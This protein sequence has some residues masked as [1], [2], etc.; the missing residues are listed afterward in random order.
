MRITS[1]KKQISRRG[2]RRRF[3]AFLVIL[4]LLLS[5][6]NLGFM[7]AYATGSKSKIFHIGTN[8]T[9]RLRDGVLTLSGTGDTDDY[10]AGTAPFLDYSREIHTLVIEKGIT[11][12]GSY[13]FYGLGEL[14]GELL[15][16]ESIIGFGDYA[17]S[18][19]TQDSAPHFTKIRNLFEFGEI[20]RL[21]ETED[22]DGSEDTNANGG[23]KPDKH[24]PV[25]DP[26]DSKPIATDSNA[27][28]VSVTDRPTQL[29]FKSLSGTDPESD[30]HISSGSSSDS[31]E[32]SFS[33][34]DKPEHTGS[35]GSSGSNSGDNNSSGSN[36][37]SSGE[38]SS[39][40]SS[41]S[42]SG[43]NNSSGSNDVSSGDNNSSGSS[44]SNSG[45]NGSSDSNNSNSDDNNSSGSNDVSSGD[46]NSSGSSDSNSGGN[47]SSDSNNSNSDDNNSSGSNDVS[48]GDNNSSGSSDSNSGDN[49]SSGCNDSNS[50]GN[51]SS[52][53]SGGGET[54][55]P[56][57]GELPA[58]EESKEDSQEDLKEEPSE[59][60]EE[61][62]KG[63]PEQLPEE[64]T[65]EELP[66]DLEEEPED[67]Y[68]I[69]DI[70][71][72]D[73]SRPETLFYPGQSGTVICS[74]DNLTF[75]EAAMAAGYQPGDDT[76]L[77][78]LDDRLELELP[79]T[80]GLLRLPDCP[81]ELS[82]PYEE[83]GLITYVFS[84]WAGTRSG[85]QA[86]PSEA[87]SPSET[88]SAE[89]ISSIEAFSSAE[90]ASPSE[91][92]SSARNNYSP[93]TASPSE[94]DSPS[95]ASALP[96]ADGDYLAAGA[97]LEV[98][99]TEHLY[100]YSVWEAT[101]R[102]QFKVMTDL[103][104]ETAVYTL[105]DKNDGRT[106]SAPDGFSFI[107]QWQ[108]APKSDDTTAEW[109]NLDGANEAVLRRVLDPMDKGMQLRC[110][111]MAIR[112]MRSLP[113]AELPTLYSD[114]ADVLA[115]IHTVYLDSENGDDSG[116]GSSQD[117]AVKTFDT[118]AQKLKTL[119]P[120]GTVTTNR[121]I[122]C[123]TYT[124]DSC[125]ILQA[126]PV[127]VTIAGNDGNANLQCITESKD[128]SDYALFLYSDLCFESITLLGSPLHIYAQG[129]N[130]TI[131]K[132]VAAPSAF[133]LYGAGKS[134]LCSDAGRNITVLSSRV[135]R[136]IG[137][138]RSSTS[139]DALNSESRI[140]IDGNAQVDSI[141]AGSASGAILN[142][143]VKINVY[144]GVVPQIIGG[145]QGYQS[146][147]S[148]YTGTTD[149]NIC[150]GTVSTVYGAGSGR[151]LSVPTYEGALK[152]T[153]N[154]GTV[155]DLYGA[156]SA[157]YITSGNTASSVEVTV[158]GGTVANLFA[159]GR[160]WDPSNNFGL[161]TDVVPV[162]KELNRPA[163]DLGSLTGTAAIK[164][165]GGTVGNIYSSGEG[166]PR[167]DH[168]VNNTKANA[169][170][171][172]SSSVTIS[173]G[174][175]TGNVYGGG[176]GIGESGYETCARIDG[177]SSI[178][179]SGSAV[180]QGDVYGGGEYGP[181]NGS[182]TVNITGGT[183][184]QSVF[185]GAVGTSGS[186]LV[187]GGSTLNMTGGLV[188]GSLYGGS[189]LSDD[190]KP[191]S[192]E[193]EI[194]DLVFVNLTGGSVQENVFGG[195]YMGTV[196]GSTH[197]HVGLNALKACSYYRQHPDEIP[198]LSASA[199]ALENS[200]YAGGDFGGE[201]VDYDAITVAGTSHVYIDGT[202]YDTGGGNSTGNPAMNIAGGVFG[203]GSSCDAG[204]TRIVTLFNYGS[205]IRDDGN[206]AT[207][208]TRTL[209]AIQRADRVLLVNSHVCLTG[210]SDVAN[211]N[212]TALYSLNRIGDHGNS[213]SL[214][215]LENGLVLQNGSTLVLESAAI[216][217]ARFASVNS[218]GN[219]V[220]LDTISQTPNTLL[221]DTGTI[222]RISYTDA[223]SGNTVYGPVSGYTYLLAGES[224]EGYVY[225]RISP[226]DS[227]P[228]GG[229]SDGEGQEIGFTSVTAATPP[230]RYWKVQ[231]TGDRE[232]VRYARLTAK[233]LT[234]NEPGYGS[235]GFSVATGVIE[236]SPA[237][238]GSVYTIKSITLPASAAGFTLAD[239]AKNGGDGSGAWVTSEINQTQGGTAI[240]LD[241]EKTAISQN[242]LSVFGLYMTPGAGFLTTGASDGK[243]ISNA[244]SS[245]GGT[246]SVIGQST[247]GTL[248]GDHVVPQIEF[249]LTYKNDI[250]ASQNL[251]TVQ[252]VIERSVDG[253][254][255]ETTVM[256]IEIV[257]TASSLSSLT[258]DLYATQGG[259]Y[260]GSLFIPA[261]SRNLILN[262]VT[263]SEG[264]NLAAEGADIK[265]QLFSLSMLPSK[266]QGWLSSGLMKEAC[267]LGS[268]TSPVR[269]GSTDSRHEAKIDFTLKNAPGFDPKESADVVTLLLEDLN[270]SDS[271]FTILVRIHW[272]K[273]IVSSVT[274]GAGRQY[275]QTPSGSSAA[276]S[277][278]S[279]VT[280]SFTVSSSTDAGG[281]WLEL[282]DKDG[283]KENLPAG[284]K[285]TLLGSTD[286]YLYQAT[287]TEAEQ[288]IRL[289]DFTSMSGR[290]NPAGMLSGT[291]T[292]ILDFGF[293][294]TPPMP[295][296]YSLRLRD[297]MGADNMGAGFTVDGGSASASLSRSGGDG[298]S[299]G[300]HKFTLTVTPGSDTRFSGGA[301]AVLSP[302]DGSSFPENVVFTVNGSNYYPNGGNVYIPLNGAGAYTLEMDTRKTAGLSGDRYT[303][304]ARIFPLGENAA[305]VDTLN[306]SAAYSVRPNPSYGLH[307][308][309]DSGSRAA[310]PGSDLTFSV[311]YSMQN[312]VPS[313]HS[314][315][316]AA[317]QK[318]NGT[319]TELTPSWTSAGNTSLTDTQGRQEITVTVPEAIAPGTYRLRFRLGNQEVPFNL[320][321]QQISEEKKEAAFSGS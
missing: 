172:G 255:Q 302:E 73:I 313:E 46:N 169:Y 317:E 320:I 236:L 214:G 249:Y 143:N 222:F 47:G 182:T 243:I 56:G 192:D 71:E 72:Q 25:K 280:A 288:K 9:A 61:E 137:Y 48:S 147:A 292:V 273:S 270:E 254:S 23:R 247:T 201:Q 104:G 213:V 65:Q 119:N 242:P 217:L 153:V 184:E 300:T 274:S 24:N 225:G 60:I 18:G 284:T 151:N 64:E 68:I 205:E 310:A 179:I 155:T 189:K 294:S 83:S 5:H 136:L 11:Y 319:Y 314:I 67:L 206:A 50:G 35:S 196:N 124:I 96:L 166:V 221:L 248:S 204:K 55:K 1:L 306:V 311:M 238:S 82:G 53:S 234:E 199:L 4:C 230:Y 298:L 183:V 304:N 283:N 133:Y 266:E 286:F 315:E 130:L 138:I 101:S 165:T 269:I 164:I 58:Q 235:D 39:S 299:K 13:L 78:T 185:G 268:F 54:S 207:G 241:S 49:D 190:G 188:I 8:V 33:G 108:I 154:G 15:L 85:R 287:G 209:T 245:G 239:A 297:S 219:G 285:V 114:P 290:G 29:T 51:D 144:N 93:E 14:E 202:G 140:T 227:T 112:L 123:G 163:S 2:P 198:T 301:A 307:V 116:D 258:V 30:E 191:L 52:D 3:L 6:L 194:P 281:L 171:K 216:E 168:S 278:K 211:A 215:N 177:S 240:D 43:D 259:T 41:D 19:D 161:S 312:A 158:N 128:S 66:E 293:A 91:T 282:Q 75:L 167:P 98:G 178:T 127:N 120:D 203:S 38:N 26:E 10:H 20:T 303:L 181:V 200:V 197:V 135:T 40:G 210:R 309:L 228:D 118:A 70:T 89:T 81:E 139:L 176:K 271:A 103:D 220:S 321:V 142:G 224:T 263:A 28:T 272:S 148:P 145:N 86:S 279:A 244:S 69:E 162:P 277:Q 173:G 160:G 141:V 260:T 34:S 208:A 229:F 134:Q 131:G 253:Q 289:A 318:V 76:I 88:V 257:T 21:E 109:E 175:I 195:S 97:Y 232:V 111:V 157:A 59:E 102:Y 187:T 32:D 180:I 250:T 105:T 45:G 63:T 193:N 100:L 12:I 115:E 212:Q 276:I 262:S 42:N 37:V 122:I 265:D 77:V 107:Y 291:L 296:E 90:A 305:A 237:D 264:A 31:S 132:N 36:D 22:T 44:D 252:V 174:T 267:D 106:F 87:A 79:L 295:G 113:T 308:S 17:F 275:N 57:S 159:A 117:S 246:N 94:A 226:S 316:V 156:G 74:D 150:G 7:A 62:S 186:V 231:G 170:V 84:G 126:C 223:V 92:V 27:E 125:H 129:H 146:N 256:N 149:I 95:G 16:P 251:G 218:D 99:E 261:G 152:I 80:D 110:R 233:T 121:I